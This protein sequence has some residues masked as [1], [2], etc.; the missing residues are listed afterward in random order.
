MNSILICLS[1]SVGLPEMASELRSR[2]YSVE[3]SPTRLVVTLGEAKLWVELDSSCELL[4]EYEPEEIELI[5]RAVGDFSGLILDY[6]DVRFA[7]EVAAAIAM[8]WPCIIDNE[9]G[10]FGQGEQFLEVFPPSSR[11]S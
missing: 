8:C 10:F 3:A 5:R 9:T 6:R 4:N 1:G 2:D 7:N 11:G